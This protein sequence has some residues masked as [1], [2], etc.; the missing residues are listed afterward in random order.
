ML[1]RRH[2]QAPYGIRKENTRVEEGGGEGRGES[3]GEGGGKGG[4]RRQTRVAGRSSR[5]TSLHH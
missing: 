1:A 2:C 5:L 4:G 3:E